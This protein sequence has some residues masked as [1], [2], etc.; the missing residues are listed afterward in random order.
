MNN[1]L[2]KAKLNPANQCWKVQ[3]LI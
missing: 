2:D 1:D 3:S